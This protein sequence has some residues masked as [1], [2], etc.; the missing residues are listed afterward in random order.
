MAVT[1]PPDWSWV[2][3]AAAVLGHLATRVHLDGARLRRRQRPGEHP[4]Q[5]AGIQAGDVVLSFD[6]REVNDMRRLPRLVAETP[7]GK[8][9]PLTLWRKRAENTVQVTVAKL[10]ESDQQL[11]NAQDSPK[12]ATQSNAGVVKTLGLTLSGMTTDLKDKF[13]LADGSKGVVVVDVVPGVGVVVV[14]VPG[15]G[16]VVVVGAV[17]VVVD[18]AARA[19]GVTPAASASA[20]ASAARLRYLPRCIVSLSSCAS[21]RAGVVKRIA[22]GGGVRKPR[23]LVSPCLQSLR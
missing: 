5:A 9:V 18:V 23:R 19:P 14:V 22:P 10:D 2:E 8:T 12:K 17:P 4:A 1:V 20:P 3:G 15:A 7:V 11:A 6:G 21:T 16:V 13:S